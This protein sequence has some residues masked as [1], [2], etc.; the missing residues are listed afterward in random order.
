MAPFGD[1]KLERLDSLLGGANLRPSQVRLIREGEQMPA[2]EYEQV[3]RYPAFQMPTT[4]DGRRVEQAIRDGYTLILDAC[5][6][7]VP[8]LAGTTNRLREYVRHPVLAVLFITPARETGLSVHADPFDIF[9]VQLAGTKKWE[10]FEKM[11]GQIPRGYLTREQAGECRMQTTLGR[12]DVLVL[13]RGWPH[14]ATAET[15]SMHLTIGIRTLTVRDLLSFMVSNGRPPSAELDSTIPYAYQ[16]P[17]QARPLL[18][19]AVSALMS[20][21]EA[22]DWNELLAS[23]AGPLLS[24]WPAGAL[25]G[26]ASGAEARFRRPHD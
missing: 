10:I 5:D 14:T 19:G 17:S 16:G 18:Q 15:L 26:L 21:V 8:G 22:D 13:P 7:W 9:V 6:Q 23:A 20:R 2:S 24:L 1:L 25:E 3:L 12:G 4:V 11:P